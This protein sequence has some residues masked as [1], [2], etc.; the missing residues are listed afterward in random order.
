MVVALLQSVW[1][2]TASTVGV[3]LTVTDT[4]NVAPE[5]GPVGDVGVT[6]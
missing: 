6:V 5:Q 3:G 2:V 1:L 4:V